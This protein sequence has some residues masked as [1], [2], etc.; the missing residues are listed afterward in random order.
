MISLFLTIKLVHVV[1]QSNAEM[2][3][4][5]MSILLQQVFLVIVLVHQDILVDFVRQV[6]IKGVQTKA[7]FLIYLHL[8]LYLEY[9][10]CPRAGIFM[11]Q[12]QCAQGSYFICDSNSKKHSK[13]FIHAY[14]YFCSFLFHLDKLIQA[15]CP[16]GLRFNASKM[17][18]DHASSVIC[19][20]I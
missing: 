17:S 1:M 15:T 8:L 7:L 20:N 12:Y 6:I 3:V 13:Y 16:K 18:C 14:I 19:S 11:D 5:V 9:F 2:V 10:R 4:Y